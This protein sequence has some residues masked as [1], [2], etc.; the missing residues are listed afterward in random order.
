M[1]HKKA[2]TLIELM[3]VVAIIGILAAI[4][5]PNFIKFQCRSKQSEAKGNLKALYVSQEAFRA[6]NDTYTSIA[7]VAAD[8]TGS[9]A[10][11]R[12]AATNLIGWIPKGSKLRYTY[13]VSATDKTAFSAGADASAGDVGDVA[14]SW[15]INQNNVLVND[16]KACE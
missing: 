13:S 8:L 3:I 5:V 9:N 6:E 12:A 16:A 4:A 2:F 10:S 7:D 14:D 15:G 11:A 1:Q